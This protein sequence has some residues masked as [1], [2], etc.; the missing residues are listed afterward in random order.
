MNP[1]LQV[2]IAR[3]SVNT[4]LN[5]LLCRSIPIIILTPLNCCTI[6]GLVHSAVNVLYSDGTGAVLA[7]STVG[8]SYTTLHILIPDVQTFRCQVRLI[9]SIEVVSPPILSNK[10]KKKTLKLS[11]ITS[12]S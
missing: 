5:Y 11:V 3:T 10:K 8:V 1:Y 9:C 4:L 12:T 2:I 6:T 7:T